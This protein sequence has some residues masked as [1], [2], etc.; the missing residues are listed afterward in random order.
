MLQLRR[1]ENWRSRYA[2]Q[3]DKTRRT[4]F[5]WSESDCA[6]DFA[7]AAVE[8]IT[9]HDMASEFRGKYKSE[10][11]AFKILKSKGVDNLGDFMGLYL[12]EQHP[13]EARVGDLGIIPDGSLLKGSLCIYDVSGVFVRMEDGHGIRPREDSTRAFRVGE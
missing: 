8:A 1:L 5:D 12:P 2:D 6:V 10:K 4:P 11:D 13:S 3:M 9:G 7:F